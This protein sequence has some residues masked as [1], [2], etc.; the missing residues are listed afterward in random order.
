ML[1]IA[2]SLCPCLTTISK[3]TSGRSCGISCA[4][5]TSPCIEN[6]S[7]EAPKV[8]SAAKKTAALELSQNVSLL[9]APTSP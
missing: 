7:K 3:K 4:L 5:Q 6:A 9:R 8:T 2:C 1:S